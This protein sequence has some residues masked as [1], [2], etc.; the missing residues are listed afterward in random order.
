MFYLLVVERAVAGPKAARDLPDKAR[1]LSAA[2]PVVS[3]TG[4]VYKRDV[5][6]PQGPS[7]IDIFRFPLSSSSLP[8][9]VVELIPLH[10]FVPRFL[11][12]FHSP[13]SVLYL[14]TIHA[15]H[16]VITFPPAYCRPTRISLLVSPLQCIFNC[17]T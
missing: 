6:G 5:T 10:D 14:T 1:E 12:S 4:D 8:A 15:D 16:D 7:S 9:V 17:L 13:A 2:A 3:V 11:F